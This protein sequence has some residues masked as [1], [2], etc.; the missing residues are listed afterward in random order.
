[1]QVGSLETRLKSE[2]GLGRDLYQTVADGRATD[3]ESAAETAE[4]HVRLVGA[5]RPSSGRRSEW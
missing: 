1:M 2:V 3:P 4:V 5:I